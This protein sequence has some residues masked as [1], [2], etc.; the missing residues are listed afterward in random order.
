ML[1]I[2]RVAYTGNIQTVTLSGLYRTTYKDI[3]GSLKTAAVSDFEPSDARRMVPC[4][5]EPDFKANWTVT[6]IH[7]D[8][9]TALSNG[10]EIGK[11]RET[12]SPWITSTFEETPKMSTYLLA[13]AVG[14]FKFVE[15]YTKGNVRFRIWS[16]PAALSM[17]SHALNTGIA[18]LDFYDHHYG[19][20][21][22][23][24][25]QDMLALPDFEAGAME[26]WGLITYRETQLLYDANIYSAGAK[27]AVSTTVSHELAHQ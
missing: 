8:G 12:S 11:V 22:P 26:N 2:Y 21:Y 17:T 5:D 14:E 23:L 27:F 10:K 3:D 9:T 18:C 15:G 13:V 6:I 24:S 25:K 16:R 7:P 20:K 19:I 4:F 1:C